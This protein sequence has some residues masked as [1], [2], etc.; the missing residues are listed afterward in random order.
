[1]FWEL[2]RNLI[3]TIATACK[4]KIWVLVPEKVKD[5]HH[6]LAVGSF[7]WILLWRWHR[8]GINTAGSQSPVQ[9]HLRTQIRVG[10]GK[11][12]IEHMK[13]STHW[14]GE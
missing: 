7:L 12:V 10:P 13:A 5:Q 3:I 2:E 4:S 14:W 11:G 6:L 8:D 9:Q 1:M